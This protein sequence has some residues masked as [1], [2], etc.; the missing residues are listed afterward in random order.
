MSGTK[1]PEDLLRK[2]RQGN[3]FLLTSHINP[4]GDAIGSELGLARLL[5]QLG[6]GAV[7]WNQDETPA[8]YRPL[9]GSERVHS[10]AEPPAGFPEK[11]DAVIVLECPSPDRTGL[12]PH[13]AALPVINIDHHLGNQHY[14]AV[15]WVDS[16]APAVGEMV[17]R[18]AQT[19]KVAL[20]PEVA[21]CL[22]LTLVTDTGGFRFSNATAIAFEAAASLVRD[23]AQPEQV[24][25][26]LY[27]SQP[28]PV[29]R[30]L[31]E[32]L[33]TL[34]L[35]EGGRIAIVR[36]DPEMFARAGAAAGDAEGLI[37]YAR[38]IAGV[39]AVGLVRRRD[40]G[41]NKVSLRSRGEVDIEKIARHHGGGGHR[42][43]AGYTL[44]G[45]TSA[46]Q[47]QVVAD[48]TAALAALVDSA[49]KPAG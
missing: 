7:V 45:E 10:G 41:S 40:D 26:W 42:N 21:N 5:R 24:S 49:A 32:M 22:Y 11:F 2:I 20:D 8:I 15:N 37:D 13:L 44:A 36:L 23:G 17:Y 30:L 43:A 46:V 27:E 34:E 39:E 19:L 29:V 9:P 28:L 35:H 48:L 25:Q 6:K 38:S 31:G 47:G 33:R 18:L 12:E 1:A 14:G 16:A 4:D 3:R